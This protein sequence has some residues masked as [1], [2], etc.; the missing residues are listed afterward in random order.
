MDRATLLELGRRWSGRL[1]FSGADQLIGSAANFVVGILLARWLGSAEY[2]RYAVALSL[3]LFM[4]CVYSELITEPMSV[5]AHSRYSETPHGYYR[6]L[7]RLH[8]LACAA[9]LVLTLGTMA[10]LAIGAQLDVPPALWAAALAV[11]LTFLYWLLRRFCY[12]QGDALGASCGSMLYAVCLLGLLALG[13]THMSSARAY[14]FA[15][16]AS[17]VASAFLHFR[18]GSSRNKAS[19]SATAPPDLRDVLRRHLESARWTLPASVAQALGPLAISPTLAAVAG[20]SAAGTLRAVQ[21]LTLPLLQ[22]QAAITTLMLPWMARRH[23]EAGA[24][25]L[26][27]T[28]VRVIALLSAGGLPYALVVGWL[29]TPLLQL[30]YAQHDYAQEVKLLYPLLLATLVGCVSGPAITAMRAVNLARGVMWMKVT[31]AAAT[32]TLGI[33]LVYALGLI[34]A[35]AAQLVVAIAEALVSAWFLL[36]LLRAR[37]QSDTALNAVS[38][39]RTRAPTEP[40]P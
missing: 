6:A 30:L 2:G 34:G 20:V 29:G 23:V 9:I 33:P 12:V 37:R 36:P 22:A 3:Q 35:G 10:V 7:L 38:S 21:N 28:V 24:D 17:G 13:R 4:L 16:A 1:F 32:W 27:R 11:P 39:A 26:R 19:A 40:H 18:L 14:A 15:G 8:I 25:G 31:A 5:L